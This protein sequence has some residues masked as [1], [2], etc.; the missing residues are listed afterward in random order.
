[1]WA[2]WCER[3]FTPRPLGPLADLA[4]DAGRP[5]GRGRGTR[6]RRSTRCCRCCS[7]SC[8]PGPRCSSSRTCSG[9]TRPR[10]TSSCCWPAAWRRTRS[11]AVVTCRDDE[12]SAD[13]PLRLVLGGLAAA[14]VERLRLSPLSIDAVRE[15]AASHQVDAE[16][17]F[18]RTGGNPFYVTE[19]LAAGGSELPPSVRDAVRGPRRPAR[20]GRP[21]RCS[22]PCRSCPARRRSHCVTA[23]GREHA[24]R[25]D[26]LPG[27]RDAGRVEGRDLVPARARSRRHRRRDRA[28][29]PRRAAP[30]RA[31]DA[32]G[33]AAPTRPGWRTMPRRR[34][35]STRSCSS[36]R[37]RPRRPTARGAHREAAAQYR[38]ALRCGA[39]LPPDRHADLLQRGAH[40]RLPDRPVRRGHRVAPGAR[41]SCV[42]RRAT[43]GARAT[44][45]ASS[46]PSSAAAGTAS[47]PRPRGWPPSTLLDGVAADRELAA[48]YGN[49]AM[50]ALN[51]NE[52]D[53]C[54]AAAGRALELGARCGDGDV[55]VHALNSL[56]TIR[57]AVRRRRGAGGVAG[58]PRPVAGGG[59]PRA[60]RSRLHPPGRRRA[61]EPALG[62]DG[63]VLRSRA[64]VLRGPRSRPVGSL[65]RASTRRRTELDRGRWAAAARA[66]PPTVE[67]PGS[68]LP[69]IAGLGRARPPA[70]ATG[71][72]RAVGRC[73]TRPPS[74][75]TGRA[76]CSG[77]RPCARPGRRR[78]GWA[79]GT[80]V[81]TD[82]AAVLQA[83]VDGR[84]GWWA[85]EIAWWRRCAGIDEPV[86]S[87]AAEPWALLLAGA[88]LG[89]GGGLAPRRLSLRGGAGSGRERRPGRPPPGVRPLRLPRRPPGRGDR[90]SEDARGRAPGVPRG[91]RSA[92]PRQPGR[93]DAPG[94]RGAGAG[95]DR[96]DERRDRPGARRL[97]QDV[98]HHVSSVLAKLGVATRGEAAREAVRLG[99]QD[100]E[101]AAQR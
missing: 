71:R 32:A 43:C 69:R 36:R 101:P 100:G 55:A 80:I 66:I 19:V 39:E 63:P 38:R 47:T 44:R 13:H 28:V 21:A 50:L 76:S 10:W 56:G 49:Q 15:L 67:R 3:L 9:P 90:G 78:P 40:A 73:W 27:V 91:V 16:A 41:S 95:R 25:L 59:P 34:V 94:G 29:T 37:S 57:P 89:R 79:A 22:R 60:R 30:D 20:P 18:R 51:S 84:A 98:D 81:E 54:V 85:G 83:C 97:G 23:L 58:E 53:A 61:A 74:W 17:L 75:R 96:D 33:P 82:S 92:T 45:C 35:T 11:L 31:R 64:G 68:V 93:P 4:P 6:R 7:T 86:P 1:M 26:D 65:P 62:P 42:G 2:G 72:P 5:A 88:T 99:L 14:G 77:R 52:F 8:A 48:A 87:N 46:R 12:L 70:G 24:D